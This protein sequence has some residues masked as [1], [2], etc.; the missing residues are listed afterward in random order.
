[1]FPALAEK[2]ENL[3]ILRA[4]R[5]LRPLKLVAKVPSTLKRLSFW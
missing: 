2:K 5:V 4:I 1:M 3:K